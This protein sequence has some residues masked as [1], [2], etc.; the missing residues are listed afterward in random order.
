MKSRKSVFFRSLCQFLGL[1]SQGQ[2][3]WISQLSYVGVYSVLLEE[4]D[5]GCIN[6]PHDEVEDNSYSD[7][8]PAEDDGIH[9]F[10]GHE[11]EQKRDEILEDQGDSEKECKVDAKSDYF[12]WDCVRE[13]LLFFWYR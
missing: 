12:S 8:R 1:F 10:L 5:F 7:L 11:L 13:Q 2:G 3:L 9:D 6:V 4:G